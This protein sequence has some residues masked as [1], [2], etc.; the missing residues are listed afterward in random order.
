MGRILKPVDQLI[1]PEL[2]M[3]WIILIAIVAFFQK[4]EGFITQR[5]HLCQDV[6]C[7]PGRECAVI[8]G[9]PSCVCRES[10]PDHWKPVCGTD[11]VSYDNHCLLHK[12][13]CDSNIHISPTHRRFCRRDRDALIA[14]EE[15][16]TQL[17]LLNDPSANRFALPCEYYLTIVVS[18]VMFFCKVYIFPTTVISIGGNGTKI[19]KNIH[20]KCPFLTMTE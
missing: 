17:A 2:L 13:A 20:S 1:M 19:R 11:G 6:Q 16:I 15:F 10:C 18:F 7:R 8:N 4:S 12:A 14:R 5:P 9:E 3:N